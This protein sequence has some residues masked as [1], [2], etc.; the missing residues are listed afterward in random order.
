[1]GTCIGSRTWTSPFTLTPMVGLGA[2]CHRKEAAQVSC[3]GIVRKVLC[4]TSSDDKCKFSLLPFLSTCI[5]GEA[6][7]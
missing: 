1:M 5:I 4:H 7:D 2:I 3:P 6:D